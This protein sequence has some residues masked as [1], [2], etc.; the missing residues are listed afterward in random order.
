MLWLLLAA[1]KVSGLVPIASQARS[2]GCRPR[3]VLCEADLDVG[4]DF[5]VGMGPRGFLLVLCVWERGV[6]CCI[7]FA[8]HR[9][10]RRGAPSIEIGMGSNT[11]KS[12]SALLT[13]HRTRR[14]FFPAGTIN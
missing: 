11:H 9:K 8:S 3:R 13:G 7:V 5:G 10:G 6:L 14:H 4:L 1:S 2:C 12:S